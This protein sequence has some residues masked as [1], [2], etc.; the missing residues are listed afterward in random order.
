MTNKALRGLP[1]TPPNV[2]SG[3]KFPTVVVPLV[4]G[5]GT[6]FA[7]DIPAGLALTELIIK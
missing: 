4:G 1:L 7:S 5:K 2:I 6:Q 3:N